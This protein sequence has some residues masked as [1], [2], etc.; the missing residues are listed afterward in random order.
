MKKRLKTVQDSEAE[1]DAELQR[2]QKEIDRLQALMPEKK[3]EALLQCEAELRATV[4]KVA[5]AVSAI[6]VWVSYFFPSLSSLSLY[7]YLS[8][9]LSFLPS[10][11]A[12]ISSFPSIFSCVSRI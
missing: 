12:Y 8:F 2:L 1:K 11:L 10:L 7:L 6:E 5:R 4:E 9:L 3:Y